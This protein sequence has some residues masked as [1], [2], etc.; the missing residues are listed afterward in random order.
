MKIP[1]VDD[2][3]YCFICNG[4]TIEI[5]AGKKVAHDVP[6]KFVNVIVVAELVDT[7]NP[8]CA[9]IKVSTDISIVVPRLMGK[10][11]S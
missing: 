5:L 6:S 8:R 4:K 10:M 11:L 2:A 1:V 7:N 9:G 3:E